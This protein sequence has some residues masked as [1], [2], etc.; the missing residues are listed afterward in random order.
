MNPGNTPTVWKQP[1]HQDGEAGA[2]P[3]EQL[4]GGGLRRSEEL[5]PRPLLQALPGGSRPALL[6]RKHSNTP[7]ISRPPPPSA[8]TGISTRREPGP[9]L[10]RGCTLGRARC[11]GAARDRALKAPRDRARTQHRFGES[12]GHRSVS[13]EPREPR[14]RA[15]PREAGAVRGTS[16]SSRTEPGMEPWEPW[17]LGLNLPTMGTSQ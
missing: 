7:K 13:C 8:G 6:P 9:V 12:E 1:H 4:A 10:R 3:V 16:P 17:W 14:P 11:Q 5:L 2:R 15:Q